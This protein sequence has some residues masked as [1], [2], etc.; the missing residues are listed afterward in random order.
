MDRNMSMS[1]IV[2]TIQSGIENVVH[3][4]GTLESRRLDADHVVGSSVYR[5]C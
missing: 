1:R 3:G 2:V 4:W 5:A